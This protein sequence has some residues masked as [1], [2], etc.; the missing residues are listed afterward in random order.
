[1]LAPGDYGFFAQDKGG[2]VKT[3]AIHIPYCPFEQNEQFVDDC[4][5]FGGLWD[6]VDLHQ[7]SIARLLPI[8]FYN[9]Q[10]NQIRSM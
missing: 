4:L 10:K 1:M 2:G 9:S 8:T 3:Y 5:T 7:S 6:L